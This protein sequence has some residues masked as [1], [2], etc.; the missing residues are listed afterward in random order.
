LIKAKDEAANIIREAKRAAEELI[1]DLKEESK[2]DNKRQQAI[3]K[4]RH[5]IRGLSSKLENELPGITG[6]VSRDEIMLGQTVYMLKLRQKGQV[7]QLPNE[8]GEVLVQAGILKVS[9][10]IRDIRLVEGETKSV[11]RN[12]GEK[13]VG[14][15]RTE[16][17][18]NEIDLRG[19]L[20]DEATYDLDKYLDDAV[21]TGVNQIY[22]IHG[23]GTGAL[24]IGVQEFL[25]G[26]PHV[27]SF[28]LGQHGE[29]DMGVTVVELK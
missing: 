25:R 22:I 29:G 28:R 13:K 18:R 2:K 1:Q 10:P 17:F 27:K 8:N 5:S 14:A 7:L 6:G 15:I 9:V 3:E 26:H 11:T 20:V 16:S 12:L 24:R 21:L 19:M 4:A 23:K